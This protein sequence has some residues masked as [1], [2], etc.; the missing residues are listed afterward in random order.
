[1][2]SY[3]TA[4]CLLKS[5]MH[6]YHYILQGIPLNR[7]NSFWG[8][9][10]WFN[11]W[12]FHSIILSLSRYVYVHTV[13]I[14]RVDSATLQN[15]FFILFHWLEELK[16]NIWSLQLQSSVYLTYYFIRFISLDFSVCI[17]L[18]YARIIFHICGL[19]IF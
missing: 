6:V 2:S 7:N 18:R 9:N 14:L 11:T 5:H 1:M 16:K 17:L 8:L 13:F 15:I 12:N 3:E 19:C 10:I 4:C